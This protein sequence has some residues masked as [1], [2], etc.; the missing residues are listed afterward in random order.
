MKAGWAD[1]PRAD[2]Q[3]ASDRGSEKERAVSE[4]VDLE[5]RTRLI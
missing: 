1:G 4:R 3:L 2:D 5:M